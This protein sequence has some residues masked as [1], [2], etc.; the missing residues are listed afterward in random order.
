MPRAAPP[1]ARPAREVRVRAPGQPAGLGRP[2][3]DPPPRHVAIIMDGNRRWAR[4]HGLSET[5]GHAAGLEAIRPIVERAL[6]RGV[7]V[8]S[9]YAFSRENWGRSEDE[10]RALMGLLGAAVRDETPELAAQGV[11]VRLLGRL[12]ELPEETRVAVDE[13]LLLTAA[14]ERLTLGVAF[15]YSG[16]SELVDA[17]RR[18]VADGLGVDRIDEA[19]VASRLYTA[20]LPDPDLLIRTGGDQRISNFLIWQ[21]A[22]AEL[23][24]SDRLW[25]DFDGAAFDDALAD[26]AR[27]SRRFGR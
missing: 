1:S 8:L 13:A 18:C 27:R 15:N 20:G 22:Y 23:H 21:A 3:D 16:R 6:E 7:A 12:E 11:R 9:L 10:V 2:P 25:P 17:A 19:A 5:D 14:G 4:A 26:Y 24:F